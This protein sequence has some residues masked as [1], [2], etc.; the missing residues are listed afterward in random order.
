MMTTTTAASTSCVRDLRLTL[1]ASTECLID[2]EANAAISPIKCA[3]L[4]NASAD[5]LAD[6]KANAADAPV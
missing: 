6:A 1:D 5:R 4:S 2:A 3:H